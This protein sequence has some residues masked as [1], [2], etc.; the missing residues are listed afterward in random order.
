MWVTYLGTSFGTFQNHSELL[1][2]ESSGC[3]ENLPP[4]T[5]RPSLGVDKPTS[6]PGALHGVR[7]LSMLLYEGEDAG[8]SFPKRLAE[9]QS[10]CLWPVP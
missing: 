7:A 3:R 10:A 8:D 9:R 1:L 5:S 6:L 2:T 4:R